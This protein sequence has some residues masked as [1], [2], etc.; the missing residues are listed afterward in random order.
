MLA[1]A[2]AAMVMACTVSDGDTIVFACGAHDQPPAERNFDD[3]KE[4]PR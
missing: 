2:T 1:L 4:A 3:I